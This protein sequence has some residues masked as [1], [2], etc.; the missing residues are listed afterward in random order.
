MTDDA[1]P[2]SVTRTL[3][4]RITELPPGTKERSAKAVLAPDMPDAEFR[5]LW[6]ALRCQPAREVVGR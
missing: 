2:Q 1:P 3:P 4:E 6:L 5:E